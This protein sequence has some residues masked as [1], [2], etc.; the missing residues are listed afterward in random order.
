MKKISFIGEHFVYANQF[1][2][3]IKILQQMFL[4]FGYQIDAKSTFA[5]W[6]CFSSRWEEPSY[7]GVAQAIQIANTDH[8]RFDECT[9][10]L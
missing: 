5:L 6:M 2:S 7:I 10:R 9:S 4:S 3:D 8:L 1:Q